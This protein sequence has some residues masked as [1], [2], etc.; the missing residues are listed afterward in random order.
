MRSTGRH[1]VS[2][3]V[4][5]VVALVAAVMVLAPF[6]VMLATALTPQ[7]LVTRTPPTLI[8]PDLTLD[9]LSN[10]FSSAPVAAYLRNSTVVAGLSTVIV[11][12]VAVPAA[13]CT[14][15]FDFRG[16]R[17]FLIFVLALQ[18]LAP[19]ALI[20]GIYREFATLGMLDNLV[21]LVLV[22][23]AFNVSFAIWL[24]RGFI[25]TVPTSL[26]EAAW[27]DGCSRLQALLRVVLP[28]I[29]PGLVT[30]GIYSFIAA[31]NEFIVALTLITTESRKPLQ[32][33]ITQ[34]IGRDQIDWPHLFATCL[35]GIVPIVILFA[36][37][38]RHLVGGL[39][40]GSVK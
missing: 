16:R 18:M 37:V 31:W 40:A 36:L 8:P 25:V 34:F 11:L 38:R 10:L 4:M 23:A 33:G 28:V 9:N 12:I 1:A 7:N 15:R 32:V 3:G 22:N 35:V 24:L 39:T 21:A 29:R 30:A 26:E 13:Y 17:T 2:R 6:G 20:V 14:A 19:V 27:L 5:T